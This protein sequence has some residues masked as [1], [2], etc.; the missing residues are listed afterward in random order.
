[1]NL[2]CL[3]PATSPPAIPVT[4][5]ALN[6]GTIRGAAEVDLYSFVGQAG[7]IISLALA[8]TGGFASN[9]SNG[10][11]ALTFFAPSGAPLVTLRSNSQAN[12]TLPIGGTYVTRV[13]AQNLAT[14][15]SYTLRIGCP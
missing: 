14:T 11:V 7:R 8:S 9:P 2:E 10:S 3:F 5:G 12:V 13:S 4:C 1:V 6:S 15:G